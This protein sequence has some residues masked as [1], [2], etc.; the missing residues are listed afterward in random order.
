MGALEFVR[1]EAVL[2]ERA[3]EFVHHSGPPVF[4]VLQQDGE[5]GDFI[6]VGLHE[7]GEGVEIILGVVKLP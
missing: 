7:F 2:I 1:L 6:G 3:F 5:R 4:R